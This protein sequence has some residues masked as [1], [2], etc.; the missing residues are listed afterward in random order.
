[1]SEER[2]IRLFLHHAAA[3]IIAD[4]DGEVLRRRVHEGYD[5]AAIAA[6]RRAGN[7]VFGRH[8]PHNLA[9]QELVVLVEEWRG[10]QRLVGEV[11]I[12]RSK[13]YCSNHR[14]HPPLRNS[15]HFAAGRASEQF[16]RGI[17]CALAETFHDLLA[18]RTL[19]WETSTFTR[20]R[21]QKWADAGRK[22][23]REF[24]KYQQP[25][26][27]LRAMGRG[28]VAAIDRRDEALMH[29]FLEL[30]HLNPVFQKRI[31]ALPKYLNALMAH[32]T[33]LVCEPDRTGLE[34]A[35]RFLLRS[36]G[37]MLLRPTVLAA[38][39]RRLTHRER[40]LGALL[41]MGK[42]AP[43]DVELV[44]ELVNGRSDAP[45]SLT[46][47]PP[48]ARRWRIL[49]GEGLWVVLAR[50]TPAYSVFSVA[51]PPEI[52]ERVWREYGLAMD[53]QQSPGLPLLAA[54]PWD[55]GDGD[56]AEAR[57]LE[58]LGRYFD[59]ANPELSA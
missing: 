31:T 55:S 36:D 40:F 15:R 58:E 20:W 12:C 9:P 21:T 44:R 43:R 45:A 17:T 25:V 2:L 35:V 41:A 7:I 32:R 23:V 3:V 47:L 50:C 33:G 13:P 42:I 24:V 27:F 28:T 39:V 16:V 19:C 56:D 18:A 53:D 51:Q 1:M 11:G 34:L 48:E 5:C 46:L 52:A 4:P 14:A 38:I 37:A 57:V 26:R 54:E 49:R 30:E 6:L 59:P 22:I 29:L 10:K 8:R